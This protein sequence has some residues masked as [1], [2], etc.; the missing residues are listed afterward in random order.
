MFNLLFLISDLFFI[1]GLAARMSIAIIRYAFSLLIILMVRVLQR[2]RFFQSFAAIVTGL[3]SASVLLFLFVLWFYHSPN[4]M[5]QTMGMITSILIIFII[6]NRGVN[7]LVLSIVSA[8]AYFT[9]ALFCL[10]QLSLN[11]LSASLAYT[12]I[13]IVLCAI[14]IFRNDSYAFQEYQSRVHLEQISTTDYLTNAATRARLEEEAHRWMNF[15]RRQGLPLCLVFVDVD[16]LK[17]I[18]DQYGHAAGDMVLRKISAHMQKQL[19]NSDTIARWGGDEF[20]LLLPNVSLKNAV[21]LLD[22][23]K[24]SVLK[25]DFE[26]VDLVTCSFGV[27][28]MGADSTYQQMLAEADALMYES[29]KSGKGKIIYRTAAESDGQK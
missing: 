25:I 13:T 7:A 28:Q 14:T 17:R 16:N 11:E 8:I 3:E 21:L 15:C 6:P 27:V 2:V 1:Q 18:N 19:R 10:K 22:R 12:I 26:N 29:K 24:D 20:V 9:M 5:I 23:V 4:L